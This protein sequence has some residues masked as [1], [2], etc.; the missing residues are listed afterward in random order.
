[1]S[2]FLQEFKNFA[3]KGNMV[4]LA[5]G[6]VIGAAFNKIVDVLVKK[7]ITPPLGYLTAGVDLTDMELV[8]KEP[9]TAA[10]GTVTDPG[11]V[12]GYGFFLEAMVDFLIVALTLFF[13][14]KVINQLKEKAED[15]KNATVPTP[16]D[17]QLL[18]DI[19]DEMRKMNSSK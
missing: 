19:R 12:I 5:I 14:I 4:D 11:V 10:D 2:K 1:M 6:V 17:I 16:K 18:S 3:V 13:V 8:L 7:I 9:V 15:E